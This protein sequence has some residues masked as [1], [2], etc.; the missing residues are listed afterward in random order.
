VTT[1]VKTRKAR[2]AK[3]AAPKNTDTVYEM[4][5]ERVIAALESGQAPWR[6]PWHAATDG[7]RNMVSGRM[8]RGMNVWLLLSAGYTSPYWLTFNQ[9]SKLGGRLRENQHGTVVIFWK[10]LKVADTETGDLK[11]VPL[12]RYFRVFNFEQTEGIEAPQSDAP[13]T[14]VNPI[15]AAE[16]IVAGYADAPVIHTNGDSAYYVPSRDEITVPSLNSY[17]QAD[18]YYSTLFHEMTHST[19]HESRLGRNSSLDFGSHGYGREELI[20][21]MGAAFLAGEAGTLPATVDNSA[22]YLRSWIKTIREDVRAVVVAA[23]A[24]QRA[25][26]HIL[27]RSFGHDDDE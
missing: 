23:G 26:D 16:A 27:G 2:T 3:T 9:L 25:A 10:I 22:A 13:T 11:T 24:A 17:D 7:P 21:E 4:V 14:E 1:A 12:L 8:Y 19:G 5:T 18:E 15:D 6:K 20:A